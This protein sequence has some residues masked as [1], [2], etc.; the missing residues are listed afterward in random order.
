M[1]FMYLFLMAVGQLG[2][3][4]CMKFLFPF[5]LRYLKKTSRVQEE[6]LKKLS[7]VTEN[8]T[9]NIPDT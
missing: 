5:I 3:V 9:K 2:V 4:G 8:V 6:Y 7:Q 1:Y